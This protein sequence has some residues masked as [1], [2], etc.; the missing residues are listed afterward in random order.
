MKLALI[1][2]M[3]A[4]IALLTRKWR[5]FWLATQTDRFRAWQQGD[6]VAVASRMGGDCAALAT[7]AAIAY[8]HPELVI[9][10]GWAGALDPALKVGDLVVPATVIHT[11][12][13]ERFSTAAGFG[14]LITA[15]TV[16]GAGEKQ[17]FSAHSALAVDMEAAAVARIAR[18][19]G[20]PFLAIKSISDEYD[21]AVPGLDRYRDPRG[22]FRYPSFV[23]HTLLR[24]AL[25]P[26][27]LRMGRNTR[28]SAQSLCGT[29]R[30]A[31]DAAREGNLETVAS[32]VLRFAFAPAGAR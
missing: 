6:A 16:A 27:V 18:E 17:T 9:S 24:P 12:S 30:C 15:G 23:F 1:A 5:R 7:R 32:E 4:E 19:K 8:L 21:F 22:N 26:L 28:L 31:L 14:E 29:L 11:D 20:V 25:W 2:A 10:V 13:G 3:P